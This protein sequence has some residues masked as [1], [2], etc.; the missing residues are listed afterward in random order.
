MSGLLQVLH[1]QTTFQKG[2]KTSNIQLQTHLYIEWILKYFRGADIA[3]D[4]ATSS[5]S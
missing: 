4:K 1:Y 2:W 5:K 3:K